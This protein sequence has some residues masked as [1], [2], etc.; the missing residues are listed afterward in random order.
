VKEREQMS[1]KIKVSIIGVTGYT[2]ME[3]LRCL[4]QHDHVEMKYLVSRQH[5]GT[6][7]GQLFPRLS[8]IDG[9]EITNTDH[10]T[11]AAESDVVF[12]CLPHKAA[13]EVAPSFLG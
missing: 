8:H 4:L 2:G 10:D 5:E 6:A 13:Q 11:V 9:L 1:S 3:L 12:L 7:L